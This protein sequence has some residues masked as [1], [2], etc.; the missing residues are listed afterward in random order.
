M[1]QHWYHSRHGDRFRLLGDI[2]VRL[3]AMR[4]RLVRC[5]ARLAETLG[6]RGWEGAAHRARTM[7]VEETIVRALAALET[8]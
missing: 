2:D 3:G 8:A 7:P 6:P 4:E 1:L 5:R